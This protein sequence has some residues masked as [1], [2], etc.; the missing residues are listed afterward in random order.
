MAN[1]NLYL[2]KRRPKKNTLY[3]IKIRVTHE[4]KSKFFETI[5]SAD[6]AEYAKILSG[7]RLDA[8]QKKT[9]GKLDELLKKANDII[10]DLEVFSFDTFTM[11]FRNTGDRNN[12]LDIIREKATLLKTEENFANSRLYFQAADLIER[13][14][15]DQKKSKSLFVRDLSPDYLK[16]FQKWAIGTNYIIDKNK[17]KL[18]K[19]YSVTTLN[20]Y[21]TRIKAVVNSLVERGELHIS[22]NPFGKGKYIIP[23]SR[24][25]KRPLEH[26]EIMSIVNYQTDSDSEIFARDMFVFSYVANGM[27]FYDIFKLK[28]SDIKGDAFYFI[29]QKTSAKLP[30]K[31][32]RVFLNPK[33]QSIIDTH[34]SRKLGNNYI[35]NIVPWGATKDVEQRKIRSSISTVNM[36]LKKI[37]TSLGITSDISTYFAR[38]TFATMMHDLGA[39]INTIRDVIGH[40]DIKSTQ[41]YIGSENKE[42]LM[43][44]QGRLLK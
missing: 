35:F 3:P 24:S 2:D 34:G 29:R 6:D 19:T 37:A 36:K 4:R 20:M 42:R 31:Q 15:L 43:E 28:W 23:K 32:I 1:C 33:I 17:E 25:A 30:D 7:L 12:L 13:F 41:S 22:K 40:E 10:D 21:L 14:N 5:F 18:I 39:S 27:N 16:A 11:R 8:D 44:L 26:E 9:K 38:H